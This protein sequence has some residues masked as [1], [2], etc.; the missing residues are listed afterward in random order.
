MRIK[1]YGSMEVIPTLTAL[2]LSSLN[3]LQFFVRFYM[4][5]K[6][7]RAQSII[8]KDTSRHLFPYNGLKQMSNSCLNLQGW[9]EEDIFPQGT[10]QWKRKSPLQL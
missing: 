3:D 4:L 1:R 8:G 6:T 5:F 2:L 7:F 9:Y 10:I